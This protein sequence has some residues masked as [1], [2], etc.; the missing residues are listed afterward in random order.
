VGDFTNRESR[1]DF[2]NRESRSD[3]TNRESRV[4]SQAT[5]A[6]NKAGRVVGRGGGGAG[7]RRVEVEGPEG[8]A[9]KV[10]GEASPPLE[11]LSTEGVYIR[12]M[13]RGYSSKGGGVREPEE[14]QV[15]RPARRSAPRAPRPALPDGAAPQHPAGGRVRFVRGE[16]RGVSD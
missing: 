15:L 11:L 8:G 7:A 1:S 14:V 4:R 6:E 3:F 12:D 13:G 5:V 2:T 16:G 10:P 9:D